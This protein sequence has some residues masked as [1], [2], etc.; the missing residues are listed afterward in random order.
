MIGIWFILPTAIV[1]KNH[2]RK[3]LKFYML[4]QLWQFISMISREVLSYLFA[5]APG[6]FQFLIPFLVAGCRELDANIRS[7]LVTRMV[8]VEDERAIALHEIIVISEWSLMIAIRLVGEEFTTLCC[9][10]AI[11]FALHLKM[12]LQVIKERNKVDDTETEIVSTNTANLTTLIITEMIQGLT[13]IIYMIYMALAYY[14]PNAHLFSNIGNNYWNDEIEN[15]GPVYLTMT[16]LFGV[17]MLSFFITVICF[18]K[19]AKIDVLQEFCRMIGKY[20]YYMAI[21]LA[22]ITAV[23]IITTDINLGM[24]ESQSYQWITNDGWINLVNQSIHLTNEEKAEVI[25]KGT[26]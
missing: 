3:R 20:W 14:G 7:K 18:W 6:G 17:D 4:H 25:A 5:N 11:D 26:F 8:L 22:A 2:F 16:I 1:A 23:G 10:V 15:I 13:P 9:T 21:I 24:D 12:T 19:I